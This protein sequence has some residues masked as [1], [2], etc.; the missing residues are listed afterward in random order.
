MSSQALRRS[1]HDLQGRSKDHEE[2]IELLKTLPDQEAQFVLQKLR[3]GSGISAILNQV[4]AGDLLLQLAVSPETRFRYEFPYQSEMPRDIVIDNPYLDSL[5]YEAASLYSPSQRPKPS[6]HTETGE[7]TNLKSAECKSL[8]LKPFHAA[9]VIE[10]R[11]SD[12]RPSLWTTICD[13]DVLM[14]DLLGVFLRCE[15]HFTAAF[16]KDYF[17][18]DMAAQR[19]DFCSSLL[20][21]VT[22]AYSCCCYSRFENRAEYW[23]PNTLMYRFLA[24]AKRIWELEATK[25]RITTIQAG[26]IFNVIHNLCGLDEIGQAYRVQALA[27]AHKLRLFDGTIDRDEQSDRIR[28]G[29]AYAAWALYNWETLVGFSFMFP[30]LLRKPPEQALPDP[31]QDAEWYGEI[32]VNYPAN[33]N[34]SPSYFGQIFKARSEFR[35]IMNEAC[36]AAYT[37]GSKMTLDKAGELYSWLRNW[38]DGLPGPLL[39]RAIVL[40]GHLQLHMYYHNLILA[41]YEPLLDLKTNQNQE[42]SLRRIVS[43]ASKCL[44]TLIRLYYLRHGYDAMDLFIV[45]PLVLAGFKCIDAINDQTP[46]SKLKDLRSTLVLIAKGLYSQRHNHYLAEALYRVVRGRMRPQEVALLHETTDIDDDK[47]IGREAMVQ[48]VRSHWP[49]SIVGKDEDVDSYLLTNL[50][51]NYAHLNVEETSQTS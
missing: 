27:L 29:R 37:K 22:L 50:V 16:Q 5:I 38:Y 40:P 23:N 34:L 43:D 33:Q 41:I 49:V 39:P 32:W 10:P 14:R 48:T 25:A 2:L 45:I 6:G 18:E 31:S 35:V 3:S 30:P 51:D 47:T 46:E 24:E 9:Q 20:V 36:H 28:N 42:E 26:I 15:F 4:K 7:I 19:E 8:Y 1:Y 44:Q 13:D 12:A 21:N 11:L 17:L